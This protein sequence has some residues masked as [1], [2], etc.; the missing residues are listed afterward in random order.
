MHSLR[1][2]KGRRRE[3]REDGGEDRT[4]GWLSSSKEERTK[5]RQR[6][7]ERRG[8]FQQSWDWK[9]LKS[10]NAGRGIL[11]LCAPFSSQFLSL[12]LTSIS[13][14]AKRK[15]TS[16]KSPRTW[17]FVF[18]NAT[19]AKIGIMFESVKKESTHK[20]KRLIDP[21]WIFNSHVYK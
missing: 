17:H 10:V 12:R 15:D 8:A 4:R 11:F 9:F 1:R 20:V 6:S 14:S 21:Y 5:S 7:E 19:R 2:N 18:R 13:P 3:W 16:Y